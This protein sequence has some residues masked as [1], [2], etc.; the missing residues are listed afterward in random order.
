M[1]TLTFSSGTNANSGN[2]GTAGAVCVQLHAGVHQGWG[3]SNGQGRMVTVV[4]GTTVGPED[5]TAAT[6]GAVAA[7]AD[8]YVYFNFTAGSNNYTSVYVY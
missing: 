6:G 3:V 4:G 7:G 5:A 8:G 2:F 1:I